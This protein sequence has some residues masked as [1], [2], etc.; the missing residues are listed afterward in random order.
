MAIT[1]TDS[2]TCPGEK[3][4]ITVAICRTRQA[5]HYPKCLLCPHRSAEAEGSAGTDPKV[6]REIFRSGGVLGR[7]P[8]QINEY[9]L[10]KV[11]VAA[12][13]YLRSETP[14]GSRLVV[15]CD[16]RSNSRNFARIFCEGANRGG[17]ETVNLGPVPPELIGFVLATDGCTGGAFIGAGNRAENYSGMRLWRAD[18]APIGFGTGLEKIGLIARRMRS[19]CSRLPGAMS[20]ASPLGDYLD[21]V[22]KFAPGVGPLTGVVSGGCG[23]A[24]HALNGLVEG[25]PIELTRMDFDPD[26]S[27]A[28]LGEGFP[29]ASVASAVRAQV[30]KAK[31]RF[32]AA[33][34]FSGERVVFFDEKGQLLRPG[35]T[36][37]LIAAEVLART[38]GATVIYDLRST[39][40]LAQRI[41]SCGGKPV[42]GATD[43]L[44]FAR[45]FRRT[46]ALYGCDATGLHYFK[47]VFRFPSPFV[48]FLLFCSHLSR[49]EA[50]ISELVEDLSRFHRSGE[51]SIDTPS[52]DV[53]RAVLSRLHDEFP[54]GRRELIDGVT[55]Y[56]DG[57]WFNLR[58][59]GK[60]GQLRLNVEAAAAR[61]TR[62]GRK[63]V[64][65]II[66]RAVA[67]AQ[68]NE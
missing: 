5:H 9:V 12:A 31:A 63:T 64:E 3:G 4:A 13:Q 42:P 56:L 58:Q 52:A 6:A 44:E 53:A 67:A 61:D 23:V 30:R 11:G 17:M 47:G 14:G 22:R 15:G 32:G 50:P 39:T 18:T 25:T 59:R 51:I 66:E 62:K 37:G 68:A 36:G 34:D 27:G 33:F 48:A 8:E 49:Q 7:V 16:L 20:H 57:W 1:S 24:G 40:A 65:R 29:S 19:G 46:E 10:R 28:S 35:V 2:R 43:A 54:E 41:K 21:Y 45:Q 26:P 55:V 60:T 38:P